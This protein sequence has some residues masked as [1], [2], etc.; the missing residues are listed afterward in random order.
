MRSQIV[1][2]VAVMIVGVVLAACG[3]TSASTGGDPQM[4]CAMSHSVVRSEL[5]SPGSAKFESCTRAT[6][7]RTSDGRWRVTSYVDSQNA[8]GALLRTE[9]QTVAYLVGERWQIS[10]VYV[11]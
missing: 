5:V 8:F 4:A 2:A 3:G 6:V 9:W 10:L 11:R 7:E 1:G